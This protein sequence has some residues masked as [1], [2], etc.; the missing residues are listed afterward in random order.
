MQTADLHVSSPSFARSLRAS[1]NHS[2]DLSITGMYIQSERDLSIAGMYIQRQTAYLHVPEHCIRAFDRV[3]IAHFRMMQ[4]RPP[5]RELHLTRFTHRFHAVRLTPPAFKLRLIDRQNALRPNHRR[6]PS[7]VLPCNTKFIIF[8][9]KNIILM[10]R[11][12]L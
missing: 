10:Q 8:N 2:R 4:A 6:E 1:C 11:S 3:G 12:S 5:L 9:A 7:V